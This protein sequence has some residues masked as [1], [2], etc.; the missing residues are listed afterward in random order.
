[1]MESKKLLDDFIIEIS[2][3]NN[4]SQKKMIF[5]I[6]DKISKE[7]Y[8]NSNI[9]R[10]MGEDSAAVFLNDPSDDTLVLITTDGIEEQFCIRRPWSAGFSAILVGVDDIFACGGEPIAAS[11]VISAPDSDL[12]GEMLN[13]LLD[14]SQRFKVPLIRGH[15]SETEKSIGVSAT[16]IG[17]IKKSDYIVSYF[18]H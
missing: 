2:E 11:C 1:M 15:T 5:P 8:I 9:F 12:R 4:I 10:S 14:A 17:R 13:G 7:S 3:F 6:M 18:F 16:L